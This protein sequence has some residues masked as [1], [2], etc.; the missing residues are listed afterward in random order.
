MSETIFMLVA[1]IGFLSIMLYT[2][3]KEI[4]K[5]PL[6]GLFLGI[7]K[8]TV[9]GSPWFIGWPLTMWLYLWYMIKKQGYKEPHHH[10]SDD[11][12]IDDRNIFEQI[13]DIREEPIYDICGRKVGTAKA[14]WNEVFYTDNILISPEDV[15]RDAF[16]DL[17]E[18]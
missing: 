6:I 2:I 12:E 10:T 3:I 18:K 17:R 11:I 5:H 15:E 16:G 8:G 9:I 1:I 7:I 14:S 4:K 13:L